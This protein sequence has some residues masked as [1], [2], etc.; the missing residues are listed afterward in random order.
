MASMLQLLRRDRDA[1]EELFESAPPVRLSRH[2]IE[3]GDGH[4]VGVAIAGR[5]VPF[6]VVHGFGVESLLYA[7]PLARLAA[8]GFRV[9]AIDIAGHGDTEGIGWLPRL[10]D[11][12]V[13]LTRAL[14]HL[15]VRRAVLVGHSLGGRL[16]ADVAAA[17]PDRV[18]GL[19]LLDA[20]VG[21]QWERLRC[22]LRWSPPAAAA[23]GA[24][25]AIDALGTLPV[26]QDTEQALKIGSRVTRSVELHVA[27]PWRAFTPGQAILR[28]RSSLPVLER[29]RAAGVYVAVVHGD[30]DMLVPISAGRDTA[31]RVDGDFVMVRGGTHSWLLRC[32]E[33]LPA[34]V[35][36]LLEGRLG[37]ARERVV[38]DGHDLDDACVD[39]GALAVSLGGGL[40][41]V[42]LDTA[43]RAPRYDW[44]VEPRS[45]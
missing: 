1:T 29:I 16:M 3:L 34:I 24:A 11:Y 23:Y 19:V 31:R 30:R 27:R 40:E 44:S 39:P 45:A 41:P 25:F 13:L 8:L 15:G 26:V 33:T 43:R 35:G 22:V 4:R 6:V 17:D 42:T 20:I 2:V 37:E 36:E 38:H 10:D 32:P 12:S 18:I 14:D 21:A 9:I 28:S 7:Q 5:G